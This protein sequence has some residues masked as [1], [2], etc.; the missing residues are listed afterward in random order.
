MGFTKLIGFYH[1]DE[2]YCQFKARGSL[3]PVK[4]RAEVG[5]R[6]FLAG[7]S[8]LRSSWQAERLM[9]CGTVEELER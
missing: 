2:E 7:H 3:G 9:V 1:P 8:S 6:V 4:A 5:I